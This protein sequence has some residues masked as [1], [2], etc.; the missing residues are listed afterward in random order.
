MLFGFRLINLIRKLPTKQPPCDGGNLSFV[1]S[2]H[3][4]FISFMCYDIQGA[5]TPGNRWDPGIW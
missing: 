5:E 4:R 1:L 3:D 2:L